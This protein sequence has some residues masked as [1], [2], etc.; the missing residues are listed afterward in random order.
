MRIEFDVALPAA[1]DI[2]A[3]GEEHRSA[4]AGHPG[5]LHR[6]LLVGCDDAT[7]QGQPAADVQGHVVR[8][9]E[10]AQAADEAGQR[11]VGLQLEVNVARRAQLE[12]AGGQLGK[13]DID[14]TAVLRDG[15]HAGQLA[16][17]LPQALGGDRQ[18]RDLGSAVTGLDTAAEPDIL[19]GNQLESL[20]CGQAAVEAQGAAGLQDQRVSAQLLWQ[21]LGDRSAVDAAVGI[22]PGHAEAEAVAG[23]VFQPGRRLDEAVEVDIVARHEGDATVRVDHSPLA[24]GDRVVAAG[25][26]DHVGAQLARHADAQRRLRRQ[27]DDAVDG[28]GSLALGRGRAQDLEALRGFEQAVALAQAQVT[29]LRHRVQAIDRDLQA[30]DAL[31]GIER[32]QIGDQADI[33][34]ANGLDDAACAGDQL[35]VS[36]GTELGGELAVCRQRRGGQVAQVDAGR[37]P[38]GQQDVLLCLEVQLAAFQVGQPDVAELHRTAGFDVQTAVGE[39]DVADI[40]IPRAL[41]QLDRSGTGRRERERVDVDLQVHQFDRGHRVLRLGKDAQLVGQQ[42][43]AVDLAQHACGM[44][45]DVA[46]PAVAE[47]ADTQVSRRDA[48]PVGG[49]HDVVGIVATQGHGFGHRER[50]VVAQPDRTVVSLCPLHRQIREVDQID[51]ARP[52]QLQQ[53]DGRCPGLQRDAGLCQHAEMA[54][55]DPAGDGHACTG[56]R[57]LGLVNAAGGSRQL[58]G[59]GGTAGVQRGLVQAN[60]AA[61]VAG[62]QDQVSGQRGD[63]RFLIGNDRAVAGGVRA[64]QDRD[65]AGL[66]LAAEQDLAA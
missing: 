32:Q 53:I 30:R 52:G 35:D 56:L 57:Q 20:A 11:Q 13:P 26:S 17:H 45:L 12:V 51:L 8:R 22:G 38:S 10:P 63:D 62:L 36:G 65:G 25:Q 16:R 59:L 24:H 47:G 41:G 7:D 1:D 55:I 40:E 42:L 21:R 37:D 5:G 19:A 46:A 44:Q 61:V 60:V 50:A 43:R 33:L 2:Q 34:L 49:Q 29:G 9:F 54:G 39:L 14:E 6:D 3:V 18:I 66:D 15:R 23:A 4:V 58:D 28:A 64:S 27:R 48:D 31:G